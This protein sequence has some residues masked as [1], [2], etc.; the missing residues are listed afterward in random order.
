VP[1]INPSFQR[2]PERTKWFWRVVLILLTILNTWEWFHDVATGRTVAAAI[3]AVFVLILIGVVV[4]SLF[5]GGKGT[6]QG[7]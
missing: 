4:A 3:D 6:I 2:L 1:F 7:R 5:G